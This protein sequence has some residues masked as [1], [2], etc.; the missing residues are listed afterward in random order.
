M[1]GCHGRGEDKK[2][3]VFTTGF[4]LE[5]SSW[6]RCLAD[7]WWG[8]FFRGLFCHF[9]VSLDMMRFQTAKIVL[10]TRR[11]FRSRKLSELFLLTWFHEWAADASGRVPREIEDILLAFASSL[12]K[13]TFFIVTVILC[14]WMYSFFC[15]DYEWPVKLLY[16]EISHI[17]NLPFTSTVN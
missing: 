16:D 9:D 3:I 8:I 1:L 13:W 7:T 5:W 10:Y 6:L 15:N 4:I 14:Y 17:T 11:V 12:W 2:R